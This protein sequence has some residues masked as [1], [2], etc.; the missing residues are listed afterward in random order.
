MNSWLPSATDE[1]DDDDDN[2]D[3]DDDDNEED[4]EDEDDDE[5]EEEAEDEEGSS[6]GSGRKEAVP[7]AGLTVQFLWCVA[8]APALVLVLPHLL[9]V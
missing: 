7:M 3:D 4:E 2:D 6:F 8:M 1:S 5:E 9:H